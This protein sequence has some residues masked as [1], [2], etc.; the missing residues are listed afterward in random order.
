MQCSQRKLTP[1]LAYYKY[2]TLQDAYYERYFEPKLINCTIKNQTD[3]N[4]FW[5]LINNLVK[6]K[7][8]YDSLS[9]TKVEEKAEITIDKLIGNIGGHLHLFLGISLLGLFELLHFLGFVILTGINSKSKMIIYQFK[10]STG[11]DSSFEAFGK[12]AQLLKIDGVP[13]IFRQRTKLVEKLCWITLLL[14]SSSVCVFL[15][16]GSIREY[17]KYEVTT[18]NRVRQDRQV[19][20][21]SISICP[22]NPFNTKY[23]VELVSEANLNFN[24]EFIAAMLF[25]ENY[26]HNKTGRYMNDED[27][28]K[29]TSFDNMLIS[30]RIGNKKCNSSMFKWIWNPLYFSCYRLNLEVDVHGNQNSILQVNLRTFL[31]FYSDISKSKLDFFFQAYTKSFFQTGNMQK[32]NVAGSSYQLDFIL[33]SGLPDYW[34][35]QIGTYGSRGFYIFNQNETHY[36]YGL[37]PSPIM[38]TPGLGT[39]ISLSRSVYKQFNEWPYTY[40]EC[41]VNG[42]NKLIGPPLNDPSLFEQVIATNYSYSRSACILFCSQLETTKACGC[43]NYLMPNPLK[44]YNFCIS[45]AKRKCASK[46]FYFTFSKG[47]FIKETCL[48]K[49]P[50]EC[51][52]SQVS[53]ALAY[54]N[55]PTFL[56]VYESIFFIFESSTKFINE[57]QFWKDVN[58][59]YNFQN[60]L[61]RVLIYYDALSYT[62]FEE[63]A[64]MRFENLVGILGGHLHLFLGMSLLSFVELI[65]IAFIAIQLFFCKFK[66]QTIEMS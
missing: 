1:K 60:N 22:I 51:T 41:R 33:F 15:F 29:L 21:P 65:E 11:N 26:I 40:S 36:P 18:T 17:L 30:C 10:N 58:S 35:D 27:K 39:Q 13:N 48:P 24:G 59:I 43:N 61:V 20:L 6:I 19:K 52:Q 62:Q 8:Y 57:T 34:I 44:G 56:Q 66:Q 23:S 7:L 2:P 37:T 38:V 42:Q 55:Y 46:F 25:L 54:Y 14:C 45:P 28:Q 5:Q 16:V 47:D 9:Y 53:T 32:A 50:L 3:F 31:F 4:T 64:D 49:C 12:K 63:K